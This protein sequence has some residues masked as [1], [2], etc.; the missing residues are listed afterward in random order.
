MQ[1]WFQAAPPASRARNLTKTLLQTICFWMTFLY[2][3][4]QLI[5][6]M[7]TRL[8]VPTWQHP[9]LE[10][11]GWIL[12]ACA[13][14]LGLASGITMAWHGAG[15]P[16]PT[17]TARQLV[18]QGPY[19]FLRNPMA[20]A[21]LLQGLGVAA[22]HGSLLMIPYVLAGGVLWQ[23]FAR[24]PEEAYLLSRFGEPYRRYREQ[25]RCWIPRTTPYRG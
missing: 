12:F 19:R 2:L 5:R 7:E 24:G 21:G 3:I 23:L 25:V 8:A 22:I 6:A 13:S 1:P 18:V 16:L 11:G 14:G 9:T 4:P 17:D 15:T 10:C 20:V